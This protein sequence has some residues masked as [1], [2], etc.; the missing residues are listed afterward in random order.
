[1]AVVLTIQ[2]ISWLWSRLF[3]SSHGCGLDS[4][5]STNFLYFETNEP[6][7]YMNAVAIIPRPVSIC[8]LWLLMIAWQREGGLLIIVRVSSVI[9]KEDDRD[10]EM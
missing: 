8:H 4:V 1:M 6:K 2:V 7:L 3:R 10:S 9:Q 5:Y